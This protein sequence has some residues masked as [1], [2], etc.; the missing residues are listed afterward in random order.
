MHF[1]I[2]GCI[3]QDAWNFI[4]CMIS[5]KGLFWLVFLILNNHRSDSNGRAHIF[6]ACFVHLKSQ[7]ALE[8]GVGVIST[9][10]RWKPGLEVISISSEATQ[11]VN[12]RGLDLKPHCQVHSTT[13][14]SICSH[15]IIVFRFYYICSFEKQY[16]GTSLAAKWLRI[17]LAIQ[18]MRVWLL[19]DKTKIPHASEQLS[20]RA[21]IRESL[22]P[23]QRICVTQISCMLQR[24]PKATNNF[25]FK[26]AI[27]KFN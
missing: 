11:L 10:W 19:L 7:T 21:T 1:F 17:C 2:L 5:F 22:C 15:A 6:F 24:R 20:L 12:G 13:S 26:K 27:C 18:G 3:H 16:A 14:S 25:I 9:V 23:P 4:T 8:V